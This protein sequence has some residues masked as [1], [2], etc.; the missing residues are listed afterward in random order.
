MLVP[1]FNQICSA[2]K[3]LFHSSIQAALTSD[4]PPPVTFFLGLPP[5]KR[6]TWG[7][8]VLVF[9]DPYGNH[10]LYIGSGT[11]ASGG[12]TAR[13]AIYAN[14]THPRLPRFVRLAFDKGYDL[15]HIGMLCWTQLP[16]PTQVPQARLLFLCLEAVFTA[17]FYTCFYTVLEPLWSGQMPWTRDLVSWDP[18]NSHIPLSEGVGDSLNSTPEQLQ[19]INDAR[20]E[21]T[22]TN[23][24]HVSKAAYN[25]ERENDLQAF[26]TRKRK[27]KASW[28]A[29]NKEKVDI[30][31]AKTVEKIKSEGRFKCDDCNLPLASSRALKNHR[32]SDGHARQV[33]LNLGA[34]QAPPSQNTLRVRKFSA[35][36]RKSKKHHCSICNHTA[37][38]PKRLTIHLNT[39][40]HQKKA[41]LAA[42]S[43]T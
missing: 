10:Y 19:A 24:A 17:I 32:A 11:D 29:A 31:H 1:I 22:R 21:R 35:K 7:V 26:L 39:K 12:V 33:A 18:L 34:V 6:N 28:A 9:V 5:P 2:L 15:L 4:T 14:K 40:G 30:S 23:V 8:Y 41:A 27:E 43:S 16:Q 38:G 25:R 37:T 36:A 42:K 3:V 13:T 20:K